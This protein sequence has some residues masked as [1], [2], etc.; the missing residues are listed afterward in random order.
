MPPNPYG[1][2]VSV[3]REMEGGD[4]K[5]MEMQLQADITT[6][7]IKAFPLDESIIPIELGNK[8]MPRILQKLGDYGHP[9]FVGEGEDGI[10]YEVGNKVYKLTHSVSEVNDSIKIKGKRLAH[11][12]DVYGVYELSGRGIYLIVQ[13]KLRTNNQQ[14]AQLQDKTMEILNDIFGVKRNQY[15]NWAMVFGAYKDNKPLYQDRYEQQ[16]IQG[17]ANHPQEKYYFNSLL[18]IID[19]LNQYGV[20]SMDIVYLNLGYKPNGNIAF[21]DLGKGGED[22][23]STADQL[24]LE[25]Q[26]VERVLSFMPKSSAVDVKKKC[27]LGGNGDGT[28]EPCNQGDINALVIKSI[29]EELDGFHRQDAAGDLASMTDFN[30]TEDCPLDANGLVGMCDDPLIPNDANYIPESEIMSN[31]D[32]KKW[33]SGSEMTDRSGEPIVFYHGSNNEFTTFD[34]NKIGSGTDAG[35]LGEG[36]YFYTK[37]D[38]AS[39]YG[40]VSSYYLKITNP[41]FATTEDNER[42]AQLNSKEASSE[43]T[44]ELK[45]EGYDGVYYNGNLRGETVVFDSN[46]IW[47]IDESQEVQPNI[48]EMVES[49]VKNILKLASLNE[50]LEI[51]VNSLPFKAEIEQ[52]GGKIYAVGGAVRDG[53]LKRPSK[54]LD[55]VITGLPVDQLEQILSKYGRTDNVGKSY[56]IIKFQDPKFGELD[57]AIPRTEK[58]NGK[59]GY[60]GFDVTA[61]HELPL[62]KDLERR[63]FTINAMAKDSAGNMIDPHKGQDD[64][65]KKL[66]RMVNPQAFKD[67]PLRML[68]A[69]QF[70][71]RFGFDIEPQ[72]MQAIKDNV[73]RIK[74]ISPERFVIEFDK[75]VNKGEPAIAAKLLAETGLYQ[76]MFGA[77]P[78]IDYAMMGRVKTMAEFIYELTKNAV[79]SPS[80]FYKNN[81]KG[82]NDT[83]NEIKAY[84]TAYSKPAK[85]NDVQTKLNIYSMFKTFPKALES[86]IIPYEMK[87]NVVEMQKLGMPFSMRELQING[88]DLLALGYT[89]QQIGE[90]FKK[91]IVDIYSGKMR[92]NREVLLNYLTPNNQEV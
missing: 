12:A 38:Q 69:V 55:L 49:V 34:K 23:M 20:K 82:D 27:R 9:K 92:N 57:I 50:N 39:Q 43:F 72:T 77:E 41:Y 44:Q 81:L 28:S 17:F 90:L 1:H 29:K 60:Q 36:F 14:F 63:D 5:D 35:W 88:N 32:F 18:N 7:P 79:K 37:Q 4:D 76:N 30:S 68:R 85:E 61:D 71:S 73:S 75:I 64:L 78:N 52:A 3:G 24:K 87:K 21:F 83:F 46:Q 65:D 89:G 8:L 54:D 84:E 11:L 40:N 2:E 80:E 86:E 47:K 42:L 22:G 91:L 25:N 19:E 56:G 33:F 31:P 10:A 58:P 67:D 70:A 45:N 66:I 16:I 53:I 6:I 62:E 26:I 59:G 74:E 48:A 15:H 51:P 13:E